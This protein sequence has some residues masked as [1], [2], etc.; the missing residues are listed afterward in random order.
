MPAPS[1][2]WQFRVGEIVVSGMDDVADFAGFEPAFPNPASAI[3]CIPV[4]LSQAREGRLVLR[5]ATGRTVALLHAGIFP[6]GSSKYFLD[7][8]PFNAG[9]YVL[10]LELEGRGI[11][12]QR[13][14]IR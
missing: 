14:M 13:L 7:A 12:S 4:E 9:A 5:D 2:Y 10:T 3:T 6:A 11:W 1:G 8:A